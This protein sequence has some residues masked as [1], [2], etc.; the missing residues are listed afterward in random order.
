MN[1]ANSAKGC[2]VTGIKILHVT[3]WHRV[4]APVLDTTR[5]ELGIYSGYIQHC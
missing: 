5:E 3:L 2:G 4:Q 1:Y